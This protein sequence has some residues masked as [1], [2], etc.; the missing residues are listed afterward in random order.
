MARSEGLFLLV[1]GDLPVVWDATA[2]AFLCIGHR[3]LA[4]A[5]ARVDTPRHRGM[6][7]EMLKVSSRCIF[8]TS[9]SGKMRIFAI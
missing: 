1:G 3:A 7:D 2:S 8:F 4:M 6:S 9:I 5:A